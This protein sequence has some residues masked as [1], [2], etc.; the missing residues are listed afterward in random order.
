MIEL[1]YDFMIKTCSE[2]KYFSH[3]NV[4]TAL[5]YNDN[6]VGLLN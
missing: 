5:Y 6:S 2:M 4:V 1:M 3:G